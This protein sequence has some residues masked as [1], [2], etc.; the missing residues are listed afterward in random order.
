[1][2]ITEKKLLDGF[3]KMTFSGDILSKIGD[4]AI[5]WRY[6]RE[7]LTV[8]GRETANAI[9]IEDNCGGEIRPDNTCAD[10]A[11]VVE[12]AKELECRY[13]GLYELVRDCAR[14]YKIL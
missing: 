6:S 2:E 12:I 9:T 3:K 11:G 1:M 7:G 5:H 10:H 4:K 8:R 14:L 13:R